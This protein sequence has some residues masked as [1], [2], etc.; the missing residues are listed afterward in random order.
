MHNHPDA[1]D[2]VRA[3][4]GQL[5]VSVSTKTVVKLNGRLRLGTLGGSLL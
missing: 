3:G 2:S 5:S 1:D 4:A